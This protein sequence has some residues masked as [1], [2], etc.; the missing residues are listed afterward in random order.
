MLRFVFALWLTLVSFG[1]TPS[2]LAADAPSDHGHGHAHLGDP[3]HPSARDPLQFKT[4][5]A[6]YSFVVFLL[7]MLILR[8]FAWG[9]ISKALDTREQRVADDLA[10]AARHHSEAKQLLSQ[11][12]AKLAAAQD[13]VRQT[14]DEA[15]RNAQAMQDDLLAK[16][17]TDASNEM[18]R[19]KREIDLARDQAL[20]QLAQLGANLAVDLAGKIVRSKLQPADH[21]A[22]IDE[23]MKN[24]APT[25]GKH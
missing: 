15:R 4:D 8:K 20:E 5:L 17:R 18:A 10:A 16:A 9:P 24:L 14:I 19:A 23:A 6:I 12:E 13:E 21:A 3:E 22:L 1:L 2:L 25:A 11:Y 7:L